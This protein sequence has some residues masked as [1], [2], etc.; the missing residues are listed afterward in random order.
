MAHAGL[1][2]QR[3][4]IIIIIIII[5]CFRRQHVTNPE[6]TKPV[7]YL[8]KESQIRTSKLRTSRLHFLIAFPE[9]QLISRKVLE[10]E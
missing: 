4:I 10:E 9:D 8:G 7:V 5:M 2:G 6:E 3:I 1:Q